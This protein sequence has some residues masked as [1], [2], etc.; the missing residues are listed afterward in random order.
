M[1]VSLQNIG[2]IKDSSIRLEGLTVITGPNNSGKT[3]VGKALYALID[4]VSDLQN[5]A[6]NDR[7]KYVLKMISTAL[8]QLSIMRSFSQ[9]S[10]KSKNVK[11]TNL[12]FGHSYLNNPSLASKTDALSYA[13]DIYGALKSFDV[14][15]L[16]DKDA[17]V[18][19]Y[20][21]VLFGAE[22]INVE[23]LFTVQLKKAATI[24]ET[25]F[26]NID[27]DPDL[28]DYARASINRTL[29]V[30]FSGQIQPVSRKVKNSILRVFED[31]KTF[32]SVELIDNKVKKT[33]TPAFLGTPFSQIYF[34]DNPFILDA[35]DILD[36]HLIK[37]Q[38][39][40]QEESFLST[41]R[42]LKHDEALKR[43]LRQD[44]RGTIL[45]ETLMCEKIDKIKEK[46]NSCIPGDFEFGSDGEF[47]VCEGY[48]LRISNMATGSKM[49]SIVK[50]LL[51]RG[52]IDD[53]TMLILDEPET[54]L[55]PS[56]QNAFAEIII[57]LVKELN[58]S[59]LLTTHSPNFMLAIDAY[60]RKYDI[61]EKTNFYQ[62][63]RLDDGTVDYHCVNDNL[64]AIYT[65]FL[66]FFSDVKVLRDKNLNM[67]Y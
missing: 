32:F 35:P 61:S 46:L 40:A 58:I 31:D 17:F 33:A 55:H 26:K 24:L 20:R 59:V 67:D 14:S 1:E 43:I 10:F 30:E 49:F 54:H 27:R 6:R 44:N 16:V 13:H 28:T 21:K 37:V 9:K 47:Y 23:E 64:N 29:G 15:E 5:K 42:I 38:A 36:A 19:Q 53:S 65:D 66:K 50:I 12:L 48:K 2:L 62:T 22:E 41:D 25:L 34:I 56:W 51:E 52:R 18:R 8:D 60:M 3:T 63:K 7:N 57:L 39:E 45:E 4:A 11:A